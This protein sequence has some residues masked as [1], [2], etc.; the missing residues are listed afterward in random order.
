MDLSIIIVNWNTKDVLLRCLDTIYASNP[1]ML[2][3]VIVLDN[4]SSDRSCD[5]VSSLFPAAKLIQS[6]TN[7]GFSRANNVG[8]ANSR[9][10]AL[11]FL[12]PDTE[13]MPGAVDLLY[14][15]LQSAVD[16]GLLGCTLL[17]ADHSIQTSAIQRY[18]RILPLIIDSTWTRRKLPNSRLIGIKP[19]FSHSPELVDVEMISGACML[20]RRNVFEQ[21][22]AFS[23]DYFM[24]GEDLDLCYR[25]KRAGWRVCYYAGAAV[26]HIGGQSSKR[27]EEQGL[28]LLQ[29]RQSVLKFLT[30][31]RGVG[32]ASAYHVTLVSVA[33]MRLLL[34][35]FCRLLPMSCEARKEIGYSTRKW[36]RILKW[37][38]TR[39]AIFPSLTQETVQLKG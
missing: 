15:Q 6:A 8:F 9:G 17:N 13:V 21:V 37:A 2:F 20:V 1:R 32:Y 18:P 30:K 31:T 33:F 25:V 39:K 38:L 35:S 12:N 4:A 10:A 28:S 26:I 36:R 23:T 14:A 7:L 16:V 27:L 19:L 34:L 3:E 11:L 24:Y 29:Q 22:G 5:A